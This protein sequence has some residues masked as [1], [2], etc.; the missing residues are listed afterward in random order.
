MG[1]KSNDE[2]PYKRKKRKIGDTETRGKPCETEVEIRMILPQVKEH[3][4][5]PGPPEV[6]DS[7]SHHPEGSNPA[8]N[9]I[10]DCW[11][12]DSE[13]IHLGC[14]SHQTCVNLLL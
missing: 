7:P 9:L 14:L 5:L 1:P 11:P 10:S 6:K 13:R 12:P 2:C 3:S 8:D 4:G